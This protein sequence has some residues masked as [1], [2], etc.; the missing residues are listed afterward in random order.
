MRTPGRCTNVEGCW[1]GATQRN[2]WLSIGEDFAC[3][4]CAGILTPPPR[5]AISLTRLKNAAIAGAAI[6][7]GAAAMGLVGVKLSSFHWVPQPQ[8]ASNRHGGS[9]VLALLTPATMPAQRGP[10][11][12]AT[13]VAPTGRAA[14]LPPA[15]P[16]GSSSTQAASTQA[17]STESFASPAVVADTEGHTLPTFAQP[18]D[19]GRH[20][21]HGEGTP[22]AKSPAGSDVVFADL[23]DKPSA[24]LDGGAATPRQAASEE[25][26]DEQAQPAVALVTMVSEAPFVEPADDERPLILPVSFGEPPGPEDASKPV[27]V[28]WRAHRGIQTRSSYF[29]PIST[30]PDSLQ[31][32]CRTPAD[33][34]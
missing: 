11:L 26:G 2:V 22:G 29:L 25:S 31:K 32:I 15:L 17:S 27:S 21:S 8:V 9:S 14:A 6:S 33:L 4:N 16:T 20:P 19:A 24:P 7:L 3:P 10:G 18:L 34:R 12:V 30:E 5:H 13:P 28:R 1:I 23:A